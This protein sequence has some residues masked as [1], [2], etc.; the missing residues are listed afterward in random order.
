MRSDIDT[1]IH[2]HTVPLE[3]I[4]TGMTPRGT[5]EA[6]RYAVLFDV[7]GTLFISKAG[8]ISI[9]RKEADVHVHDIDRLLQRYNIAKEAA[10]LGDEL[11]EEIERDKDSRKADGVEYPEVV[12]EDIWKRVLDIEDSE[13]LLRFALEYELIV[14]PVY[15]M[16]HVKEIFAACREKGIVMGIISNA[17]FYT[18]LLF[19]A[20]MGATL[21]AL[22]FRRDLIFF[23]YMTGHGKPSLHLFE[24]AVD[25]LGELRISTKNALYVGNDML[26]D[27]YPAHSAGLQTVLFAGDK[28][29][30]RLREDDKRCRGLEADLIVTDFRQLLRYL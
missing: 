23:S 11:F 24:K 19:S 29:S 9:A 6:P 5:L 28:R 18:P 15:P 1:L 10:S 8:D 2:N 13:L 7:Y 30:L 20:L 22:G 17:Q 27:I 14:N 26:K 25:R 16:P 3:P 12:I 21:E 4:P